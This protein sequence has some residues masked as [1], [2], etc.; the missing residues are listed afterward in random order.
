[1]LFL[2]DAVLVCGS[3]KDVSPEFSLG[4]L[5]TISTPFFSA[6]FIDLSG[7]ILHIFDEI[8]LQ[9]IDPCRGSEVCCVISTEMTAIVNSFL[10]L[11]KKPKISS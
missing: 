6:I 3:K 11:Q 2:K 8:L 7:V 10:L 5:I 1:M 9:I 4:K